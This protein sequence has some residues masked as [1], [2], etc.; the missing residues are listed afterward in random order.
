MR[1]FIGICGLLAAA[2]I[3]PGVRAAQISRLITF[4]RAREIARADLDY[5]TP[6]ARPE[7]GMPVGNGRMGSLVWTTPSSL[8]LQINRVDVHAMDSTTFSFPRADSDY[9]YAHDLSARGARLRGPAR[10]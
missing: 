1:H 5:V 8:K 9:G 10:G 3:A 7:E 6:A 4:D 2:L